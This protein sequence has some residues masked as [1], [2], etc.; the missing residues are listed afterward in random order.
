MLA[1]CDDESCWRPWVCAFL[2]SLWS[3]QHS[4]F[5]II[6]TEKNI[7]SVCVWMCRGAEWIDVQSWRGN[8]SIHSCSC[9]CC[10]I[11]IILYRMYIQH[12]HM[13]RS[14]L[15]PIWNSRCECCH[16]FKQVSSPN[17]DGEMSSAA[18]VLY[19]CRAMIVVNCHVFTKKHK[20]V[21]VTP[22]RLYVDCDESVWFVISWGP[23]V[24]LNAASLNRS[25]IIKLK[26]H[27][28]INLEFGDS[29]N[30]YLL[31]VEIRK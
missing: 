11:L 24:R 27:F 21:P 18:L 8:N 13:F 9:L 10:Y 14:I 5:L 20:T 19:K 12:V 25:R 15:L 22:N 4:S 7:Y 23:E 17:T 2:K 29:L 28:W 1:N 3:P 6:V 31:C 30:D 16:F 26:D